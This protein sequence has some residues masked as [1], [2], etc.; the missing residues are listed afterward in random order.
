[1]EANLNVEQSVWRNVNTTVDLNVLSKTDLV[2]VLDVH[3]LLLEGGVIRK[4]LELLK[5]RQILQE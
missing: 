5:V 4:L 1:M 3:P 2:S